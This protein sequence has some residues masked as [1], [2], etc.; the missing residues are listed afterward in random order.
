[1]SEESAKYRSAAK[2]Y[3][4]VGESDVLRRSPAKVVQRGLDSDGHWNDD[5]T[6]DG[7]ISLRGRASV[8]RDHEVRRAS[9]C[10]NLIRC[11]DYAKDVLERLFSDLDAEGEW[12][13]AR[14]ARRLLDEIEGIA[15]TAESELDR[16]R[17]DVKR[18]YGVG[19]ALSGKIAGDT[20][21]HEG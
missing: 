4:S 13:A 21:G 8:L 17:R 14:D 16:L 6:L 18:P 5:D 11:R 9:H 19:N 3:S 15:E 12:K 10:D 20:V 7:R 1:M 2:A